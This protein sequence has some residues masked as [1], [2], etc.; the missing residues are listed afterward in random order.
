VAAG[1][2]WGG[3]GGGEGRGGADSGRQA[4]SRLTDDKRVIYYR[5]LPAGTAAPPA[6]LPPPSLPTPPFPSSLVAALPPSLP[7]SLRLAPGAAGAFF[8]ARPGPR[9]RIA[10]FGGGS[11]NYPALPRRSRH[12]RELYSKEDPSP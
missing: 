7:P 10:A 1:D 4:Y 11:S 9:P 6:P 3:E 5:Q 2:E 12:P 8:P